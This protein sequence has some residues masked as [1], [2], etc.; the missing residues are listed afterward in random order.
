MRWSGHTKAEELLRPA[1]KE[2]VAAVEAAK[3]AK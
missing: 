3:A 1:E 2:L